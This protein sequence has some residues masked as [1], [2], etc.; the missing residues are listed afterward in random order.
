MTDQTTEILRQW[1]ESAPYWA[2]HSA[3]IRQM[4]APLTSAL[5]AEA[6]IS[7]G[8]SVLDVAGGSGEPSLTIADAVGPS[9]SVMYT[10]AVA[11]MVAAARAEAAKRGI[12]N[13]QFRQCTADALPFADN[14]FEVVV[15]RLGAMFFPDT[16]AALQEILRVT[17]PDG[18]TAFAVWHKSE[19]NPFSY[20]V[21]NVVSRHVETPPTDP[22]EPGAFRFAEP[23]KLATVLREVGATAVQE[24]V[25]KFEIAAAISPE[26]FWEMRSNTSETL[27]AKLSKLSETLKRQI[28]D[29]IYTAVR[30]FFPNNQMCF[31]AQMLIVTGKKRRQ[32]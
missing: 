2:K 6:R 8:Q 15:S 1:R 14:S 17:R 16:R 32:S 11:E 19:V 20:L 26:Q 18:V 30:E 13:I 10:D 7:Q 22:D 21:T 27:R 31:P 29:E 28:A 23:G 5:M 12:T 25:V 9:G 3:T 4:F 24:R